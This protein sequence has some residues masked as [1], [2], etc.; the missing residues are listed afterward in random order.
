ME[1]VIVPDT[2]FNQIDKINAVLIANGAEDKKIDYVKNIQEAITKAMKHAPVHKVDVKSLMRY[3]G[4]ASH[5]KR[6]GK[7]VAALLSARQ[8]RKSCQTDKTRT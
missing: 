6:K 3:Y 8:L 5:R 4:K 2:F 1:K 7:D